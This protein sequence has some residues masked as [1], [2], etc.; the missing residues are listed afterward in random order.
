MLST[1][2]QERF[3]MS[4]TINQANIEIEKAK[5]ISTRNANALK[6]LENKWIPLQKRI[7]E[8][9]EVLNRLLTNNPTL[10]EYPDLVTL[11][12]DLDAIVAGSNLVFEP[13]TVLD[14]KFEVG[15]GTNWNRAIARINELETAYA[16]MSTKLIDAEKGAASRAPID[17]ASQATIQMLRTENDRLA[18]EMDSLKRN[19]SMSS[20]STTQITSDYES[21]LRTS[22]SKIQELEN[23]LRSAKSKIQELELQLKTSN[24]RV[25]DHESQIRTLKLRIQ[26]L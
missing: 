11:A 26:E 13:L 20:S 5:A 9:Q 8:Q 21:K 2:L 1:I 10:K 22:S 23:E 18:K 19:A 7:R 17:T 14:T 25:S 3:T 4:S 24:S 16:L 12:R 6:E 15:T